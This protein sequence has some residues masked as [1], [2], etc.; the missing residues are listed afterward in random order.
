MRSFYPLAFWLLI[1]FF[2]A[3]SRY[4]M[5]SQENSAILLEPGAL[6]QGP[7]ERSEKDYDL[8]PGTKLKIL[9]SLDS[10]LKVELIN[11]ESGWIKDE[12]VGRI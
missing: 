5:A 12:N 10:W 9:N 3:N 8:R 6:Y 2:A 4:Q 7:D 1:L 11:K